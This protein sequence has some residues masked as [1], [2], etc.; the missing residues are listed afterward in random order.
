MRPDAYFL[1]NNLRFRTWG[2]GGAGQNYIQ[3]LSMSNMCS[4]GLFLKFSSFKE[5]ETPFFYLQRFNVAT[6]SSTFIYLQQDIDPF[7]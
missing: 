3:N 5:F 4:I 6:L 7:L 2:E 1:N